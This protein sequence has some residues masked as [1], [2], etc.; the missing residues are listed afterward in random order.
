MKRAIIVH[1]WGGNPEYC[2]YPQ[3]KKELEEQGFEVLIPAMPDTEHPKQSAWVPFLSETVGTP[4]EETYL[5]GHSIGCATIMRYLE[6]F[7]EGAK[8][9]GVVFVAGYTDDL[10][11]GEIHNFF[12]T[13]LD[14]AKIRAKANHFVAIHSTN[15]PYVPLDRGDI[16]KE[17]LGAQLIIK[18]NMNHFS[19]PSDDFPMCTSL[20]DVAEAIHKMA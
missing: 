12:E 7:P 2:W 17:Q 19:G 6:S 5:I 16:L 3:T 13:P 4:N 1:C 18:E 8:V 10:G 20:P 11:I 15:D 14:L 9:G